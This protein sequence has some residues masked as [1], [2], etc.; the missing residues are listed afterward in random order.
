MFYIDLNISKTFPRYGM[1]NK[2]PS[3]NNSTNHGVAFLRPPLTQKGRAIRCCYSGTLCPFP[4]HFQFHYPSRSKSIIL[5]DLRFFGL[6]LSLYFPFFLSF[7]QSIS[8]IP[9]TYLTPYPTPDLPY[10]YTVEGQ[11][12]LDHHGDSRRTSDATGCQL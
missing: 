8:L 6:F 5:L 1:V 3:S 9:Y 10:P 7:V 2:P 12:Y 4:H 11:T